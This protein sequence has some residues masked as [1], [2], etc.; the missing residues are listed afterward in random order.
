MV[1]IVVTAFAAKTFLR[2][3]REG[4]TM[5]DLLVIYRAGGGFEGTDEYEPPGADHWLIP[6]GLPDACF[7]TRFNTKLGVAASTGETPAW[8]AELGTCEVTATAQLRQQGQLWIAT[9]APHAGYM[10]LRLLRYPAWRITVNGQPGGALPWRDDGLIAIPVP[11]GPVEVAVDWHTTGDVIAGR[12]VSCVAA[13]LLALV[14]WVERK[15]SRAP[16]S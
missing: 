12:F 8:R 16:L 9:V 6:T 11:R 7:T 5:Q 14:W 4:D 2:V 15:L 10:I 13:L 1:F 3:C